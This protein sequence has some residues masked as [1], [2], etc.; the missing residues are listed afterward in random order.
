MPR[1]GGRDLIPLPPSGLVYGGAGGFYD[2]EDDINYP[3]PIQRRPPGVLLPR[4][5]INDIQ[6]DIP[7]PGFWPD[8]HT[9]YNLPVR[10]PTPPRGSTHHKQSMKF[11]PWI[12]NLTSETHKCADFNLFRHPRPEPREQPP[13]RRGGGGRDGN[14]TARRGI[15]QRQQQQQPQDQRRRRRG[16]VVLPIMP[17][18][19]RRIEFDVSVMT[20]SNVLYTPGAQYSELSWKLLAQQGFTRHILHHDHMHDVTHLSPA[21][22]P[23]AGG[24]EIG[25]RGVRRLPPS[26]SGSS[27]S[28]LAR[29]GNSRYPDPRG[30]APNDRCG[31]L[32][33]ESSVI[34][35][36]AVPGVDILW[37]GYDKFM[38]PR[39]L[40]VH[41][42]AAAMVDVRLFSWGVEMGVVGRSADFRGVV[43]WIGPHDDG[44]GDG[45]RSGEADV[46]GDEDL[47]R[48]I[49]Q[50]GLRA[51]EQLGVVQPSRG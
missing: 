8:P 20:L 50:G 30:P 15:Q 41:M 32:D 25:W 38:D 13:P 35:H 39:H 12:L 1:L 26:S 19:R 27:R 17:G 51:A 2:E 18:P 7:L 11:T 37:T 40:H 47:F 24:I 31:R 10:F 5:T 16:T 43:K 36:R 48:K 46:N 29:R 45:S 33:K 6:R 14:A 3:L 4:P 49:V 28:N 34:R 42:T 44:D 23:P 22:R 21:R 9:P